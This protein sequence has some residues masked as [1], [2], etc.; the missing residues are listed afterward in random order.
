MKIAKAW[1]SAGY[2]VAVLSALH[3]GGEVN[4]VIALGCCVW[5]D[6]TSWAS[7]WK[8]YR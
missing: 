4:A 7:S 3:F 8:S 2:L 1:T 6:I 5:I